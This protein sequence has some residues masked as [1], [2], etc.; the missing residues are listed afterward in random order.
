LP[1]IKLEKLNQ[2]H[3]EGVVEVTSQAFYGEAITNHVYDFSRESVR[4]KYRLNA[5]IMA[6]T[7]LKASCPAGRRPGGGGSHAQTS[8]DCTFC[9]DLEN[10]PA[11]VASTAKPLFK[12]PAPAGD[13][14]EA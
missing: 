11:E 6:L 13:G 3:L 14:F 8:S 10:I 5:E 7:A 9:C 12:G 1:E 2:K 4:K